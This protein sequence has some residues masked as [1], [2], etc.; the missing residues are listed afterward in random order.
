MPQGS[1]IGP[2]LFVLHINDLPHCVRIYRNCES[3]LYADDN[4]L[5]SA[6]SDPLDGYSDYS[7]SNKSKILYKV[8]K[9]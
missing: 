6:Y 9:K 5:M 3:K 8:K 7:L 4:K 1:V 2:L